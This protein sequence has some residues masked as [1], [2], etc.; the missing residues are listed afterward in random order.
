MDDEEFER[1]M[2]KSAIIAMVTGVIIA[3]YL[4]WMMSHESYSALYIYPD[5]YSNYV[6]PGDVVT[7]RYGVKSY[8]IHETQYFLKIYLGNKLIKVKK[9][10]L[11]PGDTWE[12]NE[13][14]KLPKDIKFPTKVMLVLT[15][16]NRTYEVHF[17][18]KGKPQ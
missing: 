12:E 18:L 9:F 13:S 17:W 3:G 7:F 8:E 15:A 6:K 5:S 10:K 1:I 11:R 2:M 14:V 4:V 16:N